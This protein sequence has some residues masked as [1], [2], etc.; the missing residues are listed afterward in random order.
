MKKSTIWLLAIVMGFAFAGLLYLQISYVNIILKTRSEQFNDTVKRS[1]RQVSK[2]LELEE[3]RANA[4]LDKAVFTLR[5]LYELINESLYELGWEKVIKLEDHP[6]A[7]D[8][9]IVDFY[10]AAA[11]LVIELDG[12]QH[13]EEEGKQK[14]RKRDQYLEGLGL[15]VKRYSNSDINQRFSAVCEDIYETIQERKEIL[16]HKRT[17]KPS[18]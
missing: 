15:L 6:G 14:D 9:Y 4:K 5:R 12:S 2:N 13:Y 18:P 16:N 3:Y 10:C 17:P 11:K 8:Q 1:L 7:N